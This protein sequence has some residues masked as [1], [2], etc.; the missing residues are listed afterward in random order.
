[1]A[2][3]IKRVTLKNSSPAIHHVLYRTKREG[4][5]VRCR[6]QLEADERDYCMTIR[7]QQNTDIASRKVRILRQSQNFS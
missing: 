7:E 3:S 1:M 5:M 4:I 6:T 2:S